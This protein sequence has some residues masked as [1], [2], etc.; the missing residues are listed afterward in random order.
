MVAAQVIGCVQFSTVR[1]GTFREVPL[2]VGDQDEP[3][4]KRVRRDQPIEAAAAERQSAIG[5]ARRLVERQHRKLADHVRKLGRGGGL[6]PPSTMQLR[7][8]RSRKCTGCRTADRRPFAP[9]AG[10][11]P[12]SRDRCTDSCRA[13]GTAGS[14]SACRRRCQSRGMSSNSRSSLVSGFSQGIEPA[15]PV[16]VD[17]PRRS[18]STGSRTYLPC[19][20]RT[21]IS[22]PAS[23][24]SA[25]GRRTAIELPDLKVFVVFM[26][27]NPVYT[28]CIYTFTF[29]T[30]PCMRASRT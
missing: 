30:S 18:V 15:M 14:L 23:M 17:L 4:R 9:A 5:P 25:L 8:A 12:G 26:I 19:S 28:L 6:R 10:D 29:A 7:P 3:E 21:R 24:P 13:G 16:Q 2:V 22:V 11:V 27:A 20:S 1:P